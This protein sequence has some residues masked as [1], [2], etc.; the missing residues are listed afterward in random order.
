VSNRAR[1]RRRRVNAELS[2]RKE[3]ESRRSATPACRARNRGTMLTPSDRRRLAEG[4]TTLDASDERRISKT[5]IFLPTTQ[6]HVLFF[7]KRGWMD[8]VI[9]KPF[10]A[11]R[12]LGRAALPQ[13]LPRRKCL[14][15]MLTIERLGICNSPLNARN[16]LKSPDSDEGI[17][18]NARNFQ[19]LIQGKARDG[20]R[21]QAK[22]RLAVFTE[23]ES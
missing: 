18:G 5:Y 19:P 8:R 9:A 20:K 6:N 23:R 15:A 2:G 11:A 14:L 17:L 10:L 7:R 21:K 4:P 16:P 1:A 22:R 12:G 13:A 3:Y